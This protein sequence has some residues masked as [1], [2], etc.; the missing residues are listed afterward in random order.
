MVRGDLEGVIQCGRELKEW[1]LGDIVT[2]V[3]MFPQLSRWELAQTLCEHLGWVSATGGYKVEACRKLLEKLEVRGLVKLP[4][5][6]AMGKAKQEGVVWTDRTAAQGEVVGTVGDLGEAGLEVV[7]SREG[8]GLW[9]EY[10]E[11]YHYLGAKRPFGCFMRYFIECERGLLGCI[12]MAG[13]AKSIGVRE[14]WI[15]WSEGQRL[16][17]LGWVI[18]NSRFLIFPWVRVRN[19]ASH[20]LGQLGCRVGQDWYER[21]GY[22]PVLMETFVDPRHFD[23]GCYKAANWQYLGMTTGEGL[24]RAGKSYRTSPRKIFVRPLARGFRRLLC[25]DGLAGEVQP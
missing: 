24:V 9:E 14:R 7:L 1:E 11:R 15:G 6:R 19:L 10:V 20:V 25:W 4:G 13:A 16:R 12:L 22:R 8:K 2:T 5:K 18:N 3:E 23:G 17:N 21:W